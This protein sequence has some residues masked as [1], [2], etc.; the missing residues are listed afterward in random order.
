MKTWFIT[1]A[2]RGLG[3]EIARAALGNGDQV[4]ATARNPAQV[5][6]ALD[7][8][9]ERLFPVRLDVTDIAAVQAAVSEAVERFG[10][11]DVLVNNAGYGQLGAFEETSDE[12]IRRQFATNV[13]GVFSVTRQILPIMR[14]QRS[15]H[16]ITISSMAGLVAFDGSSIYSAT[17][18]ALEGWSESLHL[19]LQRF[20]I[21]ATVVEPGYFRTDFLDPRSVRHGDIVIDD[22]ESAAALKKQ[23]ISE[24]NHR[25]AG[26]PAKLGDAI[27]ALAATEVPPVRF[28]AGTDAY[29]AVNKKADSLRA[30]AD[31][32]RFLSVSTDF[33]A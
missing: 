24:R 20:G 4:A 22:Y 17:K 14:G 27:V 18:F 9:G 6:E 5:A 19:E 1:G 29:A 3:L 13:F 11:I 16:V 15:G 28:A 23:S 7:G 32:W 21:K 25:Q 26:D 10:R 2:S 12:A 8:Y 30:E 31:L 33:E